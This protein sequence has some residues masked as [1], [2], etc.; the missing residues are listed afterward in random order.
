M[1]C[2]ESGFL[3][4]P[5]LVLLALSMLL[6]QISAVSLSQAAQMQAAKQDGERLQKQASLIIRSLPLDTLPDPTTPAPPGTSCLASGRQLLAQVERQGCLKFR[7]LPA[8][9]TLTSLLDLEL[10]GRAGMRG[11]WQI[12]LASQ[13]DTVQQRIHLVRDCLGPQRSDCQ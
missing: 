8:H 9:P 2:R 11:H 6:I 10:E 1:R 13:P 12:L 7:P 4:L 5:L 3:L